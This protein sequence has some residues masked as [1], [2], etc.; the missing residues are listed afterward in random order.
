MPTLNYNC[1]TL[2]DHEKISCGNWKKGGSSA[3][4]IIEANY[5]VT[6]WTSKSDWDTDILAGKIHLLESIKVQIPEPAMVEGENPIGAGPDNILD[7][8]DHTITFQDFNYTAANIDFYNA[9]NERRFYVAVY[10]DVDG[11]VSVN[12]TY[13]CTAMVRTVTP[14]SKKEKRHFIGTIQWTGKDLTPLYDA[15]IGVF[16]AD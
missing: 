15:P 16:N 2:G 5:T 13:P 8:F 1:T 11:E 12:V 14:L 7:S 10:H 4:A 6:D 3:L 9:L